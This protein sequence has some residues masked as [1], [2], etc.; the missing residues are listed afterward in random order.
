MN[1][2]VHF[3]IPVN[4]VKRAQ[5]FYGR[6]FG[7]KIND[8]PNM[9]Y[10]IVHTG[11]TDEKAGMLKEPG[12]INGGMMKRSFGIK[13]PVITIDVEDIEEAINKV[14]SGG[15]RSIRGKT[16]VGDM[17]YSAYIEDTE[18]NIIGL[19]QNKPQKK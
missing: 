1:K 3:E 8:I 5:D 18:G 10:T 15:G 6:I 2:V 9:D 17:G 12:F 19:W 16:D 4:D 14:V 11:P 7:W 13:S